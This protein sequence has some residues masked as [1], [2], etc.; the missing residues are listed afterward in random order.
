MQKQ[1][2]YQGRLKRGPLMVTQME[3]QISYESERLNLSKALTQ[4]ILL[5]SRK[6]N[7]EFFCSSSFCFC[8]KLATQKSATH[9]R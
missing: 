3:S 6:I 2:E 4:E 7:P 9:Y 8:Q 1:E 5:I